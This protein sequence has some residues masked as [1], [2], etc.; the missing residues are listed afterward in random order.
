M[1]YPE[2]HGYCQLGWARDL[3]PWG[4]TISYW[5]NPVTEEWAY[6]YKHKDGYVVAKTYEDQVKAHERFGVPVTEPGE[7]FNGGHGEPQRS[8][9]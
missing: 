7:H 3:D 2:L 4:V 6:L 5:F 1:K 9:F 8:L